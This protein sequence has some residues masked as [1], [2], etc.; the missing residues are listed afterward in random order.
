MVWSL[1]TSCTC[2]AGV[3]ISW[4]RIAGPNGRADVV[5]LKRI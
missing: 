4:A 5:I 2:S 1:D 3:A